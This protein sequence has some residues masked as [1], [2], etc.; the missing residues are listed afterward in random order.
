MIL[1][2]DIVYCLLFIVYRDE[3]YNKSNTEWY[4]VQILNRI[5]DKIMIAEENW[6]ISMQFEHAIY[7]IRQVKILVHATIS[8]AY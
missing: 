5:T 1:L 3:L 2:N 8:R 4:T 6:L 7:L